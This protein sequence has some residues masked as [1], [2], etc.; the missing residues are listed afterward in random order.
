MVKCLENQGYENTASTSK[1]I[2]YVNKFFDC[3]N[4]KNK[5]EGARKR[6]D[7]LRPSV[8]AEDARLK[9]CNLL[10]HNLT[11]LSGFYPST[12]VYGRCSPKTQFLYC[13]L[14][15]LSP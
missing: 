10:L 2:I 12:F 3:L 5:N 15:L 13:L 11:I 7:E 8:S 6:N 4:V 14:S 9:V 1:V